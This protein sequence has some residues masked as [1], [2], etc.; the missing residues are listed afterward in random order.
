MPIVILVSKKRSAIRP[1]AKNSRRRGGTTMVEFAIVAIPVFILFFGSIEF[2]RAVMGVQAL[3]EAARSGC[4]IAVLK[5]ATTSAV[6]NEIEQLVEGMGISDHTT[7]IIPSSLDLVPQWEAVTVRV[8]ASFAD[9]SWLPVP[10]AFSGLSYTA[11]CVLPREG[12][13]DL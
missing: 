5:S 2:G 1:A 3:E 9:I 8:T 11:S 7:Q 12:D 10:Q 4:R 6:E 13:L